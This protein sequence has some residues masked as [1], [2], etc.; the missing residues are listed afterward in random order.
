M[1]TR[2]F[3]LIELLVVIAII[4]VLSGMLLPAL[5]QAREKAK[6]ISCV[7]NLKQLGTGYA[8][9]T[10]DYD[11]W[12][13]ATFQAGQGGGI[14]WWY[15]CLVSYMGNK[16][17]LAIRKKNAANSFQCPTDRRFTQND[18]AQGVSYGQNEF[19]T[20]QAPPGKFRRKITG[21]KTTSKVMILSD[22]VGFKP[23]KYD[24]EDPYSLGIPSACQPNVTYANY[25]VALD[26]RHSDRFNWLALGGNARGYSYSDLMKHYSDSYTS[27]SSYIDMSSFWAKSPSIWVK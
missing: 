20:R 23:G 27:G 25:W 12:L 1:K 21:A 26:Y 11:D 9:Y 3:T 5:N 2:S 8:M 6:S 4:A 18:A 17:D 22:S 19:I 14:G 16:M 15:S 24:M 7:N 10:S 13:P